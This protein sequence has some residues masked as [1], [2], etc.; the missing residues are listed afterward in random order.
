LVSPS[1]RAAQAVL[2]LD[3]L[4]ITDDELLGMLRRNWPTIAQMLA[5]GEFVEMNRT[6][7]ILHA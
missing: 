2:H 1:R 6:A 4:Y 7:V 5:Q 3:R